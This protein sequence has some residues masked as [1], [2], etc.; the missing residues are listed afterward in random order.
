MFETG[1]HSLYLM[2][3]E[4]TCSISAENPGGEKGGGAKAQPNPSSASGKLGAGWKVRP[5]IAVEPGE[6]KILADIHG[7]GIIR[8]I[9]MTADN[10]MYRA[11]I[12]RFYWD[13]ETEPSVEVPMADFFA[14]G[15]GK[16]YPVHSLP[17]VVNPSGGM[18]CYWPMPFRKNC[19]ITFTNEHHQAVRGFF[20]QITFSRAPVDSHAGYFHAQWR[21]SMTT[22]GSPEHVIADEIR[23]QGQYV[24]TFLS[25][26]QYS[27]CWWGEGEV[28]FYLDGDR[29]YP[30]ICGTGTE[31]YFGGAWNFGG[32]YITTFGQTYSTPFLGFPFSEKEYGKVPKHALYRWHIMDPIRFRMD[33]K[34]TV[35]ALGWW[36]D[37]KYQPLTEDI[38]SVA[39][40]YQS[41]PHHRFPPLAPL[42]ERWP[43]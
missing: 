29:E 2:N 37:G 28:K 35:Q 13:G 12:L 22:R 5:C 18:N 32:D 7:S 43:R 30:T 14:L 1:L 16:T 41:E 36:P 31:D 27:D 8:H 40:W 21:R 11:G 34:V 39:Y 24:G 19:R 42:E 3:T 6:T 15:H 17:V 4:E 23:G 25:W 20:Y 9:W 10:R 26:M 38:A 33:L